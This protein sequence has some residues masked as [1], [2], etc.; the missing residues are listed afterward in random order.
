MEYKERIE[1]LESLN[2][3]INGEYQDDITL[4]LDKN[5]EDDKWSVICSVNHWFGIVE[6]YLD[7]EHILDK[8]SQDYN[9][10]SVYLFLSSVDIVIEG[11]NDIN[12]IVKNNERARLFFGDNEIFKDTQKDDWEYFK[13]IRAIFGAHPTQLKDNKEYIVAT[14]PTPYNSRNDI[15]LGKTR[16]WDY[17]TLLWSKEKSDV[18]EQLEFGFKFE[19]VER[20][21]DKCINYL[22]IIYE[23]IIKMIERYK[24][25]ISK[26]KI[27]KMD[28]PIEQL[29][30]LLLEDKKRFNG[31]YSCEINSIKTLVET[32]ITD[33]KNE[34]EYKK[35]R[36]I[37]INK[38]PD[39]FNAI[40]Y[41]NKF[42]NIEKLD[43]IIY[44]DSEY[45]TNVSSYYYPKLYEYWNNEDMEDILIE[46]FKNRIKPF[47]NNISNI[48][49]LYC[50]V[51]AYNYL[52]DT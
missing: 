12:K 41:P 22:D 43:N 1:K 10:G 21:L 20:Y 6:K 33:N 28:N 35:Y 18:L 38:I 30:I 4:M 3:F 7:S 44:C 16:G 29:N 27:I 51:K 32:K 24:E 39:L 31:R 42:K 17:Y 52:R 2:E 37:L 5:F 26:E 49:E 34:K 9:W 13:N 15:L 8:E 45:F 25:D 47:N 19:D 11:I 50:I 36:E 14:Y 48:E 46:Y 23:N 40:Q